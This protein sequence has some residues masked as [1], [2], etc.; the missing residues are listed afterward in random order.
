MAAAACDT[1]FNPVNRAPRPIFHVGSPGVD[2]SR[3][4]LFELYGHGVLV[5]QLVNIGFQRGLKWVWRNSGRIKTMK[6][7]IYIQ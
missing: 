4:E 1:A 3:V 5:V 6:F 2:E 7:G